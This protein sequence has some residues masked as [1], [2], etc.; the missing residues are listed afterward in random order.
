MSE[1]KKLLKLKTVG[2]NQKLLKAE[3]VENKQ[4]NKT[5]SLF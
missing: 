4:I 5:F 3:E 2:V 1:V